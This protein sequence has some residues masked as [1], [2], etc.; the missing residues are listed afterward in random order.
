M[1]RAIDFEGH[2]LAELDM[3]VCEWCELVVVSWKGCGG[4]KGWKMAGN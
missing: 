2:G 1:V 4:G 3:V